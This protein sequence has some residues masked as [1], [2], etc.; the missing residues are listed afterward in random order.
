MSE[1]DGDFQ[2]TTRKLW[3]MSLI[4]GR[5]GGWRVAACGWHLPPWNDATSSPHKSNMFVEQ[6]LFNCSDCLWGCYLHPYRG[7]DAEHNSVFILWLV[8]FYYWLPWFNILALAYVRLELLMVFLTLVVYD[9]LIQIQTHP[10][11]ANDK[12]GLNKSH[13]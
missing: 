1:L 9:A 6:S 5:V 7:R 12:L 3:R 4:T 2:E 10:P 13:V 11:P 8:L